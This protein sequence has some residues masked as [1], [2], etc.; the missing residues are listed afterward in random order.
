MMAPH[1][2]HADA[3]CACSV[4]QFAMEVR[5]GGRSWQTAGPKRRVPWSGAGVGEFA[6]RRARAGC[7]LEVVRLVVAEV[8]EH[9][10]LSVEQPHRLPVLGED[11][12]YVV[13]RDVQGVALLDL[14][15]LRLQGDPRVVLL[16]DLR[17]D[18]P[19]QRI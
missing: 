13:L 16:G 2:G 7:R 11:L 3:R 15:A 4:A 18:L 6:D 14:V 19:L 5:S 12:A 8:L 17:L 1:R 10:V 9:P